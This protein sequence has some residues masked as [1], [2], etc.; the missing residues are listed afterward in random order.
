MCWVLYILVLWITHCGVIS[1][2]IGESDSG[3]KFREVTAKGRH[4]VFSYS[5]FYLGY[6]G[7]LNFVRRT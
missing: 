2:M 7:A 4:Y 6:D 3:P 5:L 1:T